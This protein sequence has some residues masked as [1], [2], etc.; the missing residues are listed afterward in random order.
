M[1]EGDVAEKVFQ[2]LTSRGWCLKDLS[3]VEQVLQE[4]DQH[5]QAMEKFVEGKL[6]DMDLKAIGGKCL[7]DASAMQRLSH[8]QGPKVLQARIFLLSVQIAVSCKFISSVKLI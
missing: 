5:P 1:T 8:L 3:V 7:P 2:F 6:L 4:M